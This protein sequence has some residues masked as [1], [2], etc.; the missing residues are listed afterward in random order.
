MNLDALTH[1]FTDLHPVVQAL[2]AT[3]F[4]WL[5]TASGAALVFLF[6]DLPRKA[7]DGMLGFTGGVMG[8]GPVQAVIFGT[9]WA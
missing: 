3:T 4:T 8:C 1:A 5:V 6:K 2:L 7:L 9:V